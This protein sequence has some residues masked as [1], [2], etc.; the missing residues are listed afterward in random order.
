MCLHLHLKEAC[1]QINTANRHTSH[2]TLLCQPTLHTQAPSQGGGGGGG[3]GKGERKKK[4]RL[5]V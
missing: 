5:L 1:V 3:G 2:C 4:F